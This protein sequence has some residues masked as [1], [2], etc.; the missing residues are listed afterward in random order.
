MM[1]TVLITGANR[2]LGLELVRQYAGDGWRVHAA[3]RSPEAAEELAGLRAL[4]DSIEIHALDVKSAASIEGLAAALRGTP[5]DVLLNNAGVFGPRPTGDADPRQSFGDVDPQIWLDVVQ[6]NA[7][8]PLLI[9]QAFVDHV[10]A[11]EQKKIVAISSELGSVAGTNGGLYAYRASKAA[12]NMVMASLA[13][14]LAQRGILIGVYCP[15]WV[16]TSMGGPE[17]PLA[18]G[19]SVSGLRRRIAEL[20]ATVSGAFRLYDGTPIA[21]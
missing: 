18:A 19:D 15:G 8:A 10:A 13:R 6:V 9:S 16:R 14:E 5:I 7:L 2:G 3:C 12:L 11:S 4:H 1:P 17:A 21:W 20:D